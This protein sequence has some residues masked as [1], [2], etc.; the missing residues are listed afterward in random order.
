MYQLFSKYVYLY[1]KILA[2]LLIVIY[3]LFSDSQRNSKKVIYFQV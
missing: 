1:R 3:L 2:Q